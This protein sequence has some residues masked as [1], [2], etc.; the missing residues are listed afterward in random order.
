MLL[1]AYGRPIPTARMGFVPTR[2]VAPKVPAVVKTEPRADAVG[3]TVDCELF[4]PL[5]ECRE[6]P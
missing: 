5:I 6:T 3:Y 2:P 4:Y 1:D